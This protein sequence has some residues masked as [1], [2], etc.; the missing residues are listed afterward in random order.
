MDF[1]LT[2]T[3]APQHQKLGPK[4]ARLRQLG[5]SRRRIAKKLGI[6]DKTVAKS[7]RWLAHL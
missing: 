6:N 1:P 4:I 3:E 2:E 7:L 5:L